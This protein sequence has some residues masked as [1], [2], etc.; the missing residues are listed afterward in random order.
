MLIPRGV[1]VSCQG[2][3]GTPLDD[4][5]VMTALARAA[6]LAGAVAIRAQGTADI[7]TIRA[8]VSVP[9]IGLL[10]RDIRGT[11]WITPTIEDAQAVEAA[12]A[13]MVAMDLTS[14]P[15]PDGLS[16]P[17][18]VRQLRSRIGVPVLAD[19]STVVEGIAAARAGASC[20]GSTLS[21]YTEY[22]RQ[23][24]GPDIELVAELVASVD[25]PIFAEG[26]Y[27]SEEQVVEAFRRG[28]HA[29]VVGTAITNTLEIT[30][31]FV[32]ASRRE[33]SIT[34]GRGAL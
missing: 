18:L 15:R 28:A 10:K 34:G 27:R 4:P 33:L 23:L 25:V 9:I 22:S 13:D 3:P 17:E 21:G 14:R 1:I 16:V 24:N 2:P 32:D 8:A 26:R 5:Y 30:R 6:E 12:G 29:V 19:V 7:S 20:I 11:R 31:W